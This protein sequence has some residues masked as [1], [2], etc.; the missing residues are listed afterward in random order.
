MPGFTSTRA[1][2][3]SDPLVW[4]GSGPPAAGDTA[5]IAVVGSA[6]SAAANN[7]SGLVR[8][9]V[10]STANW[11][12]G[13][14]AAIAGVAGTTEAN[15]FWVVTV[16][17]GTHIDLQGSA[18]VSAY[19]GG[20]RANCCVKVDVTTTVGSKAGGVGNGFT[21]NGTNATTF[22]CLLVA[23][24]VEFIARGFDVTSNPIGLV[25]QFGV[26][27]PLVGSVMTGD[28][29]SDYQSVLIN[30][31]RFEPQSGAIFGVPAASVSWASK[32]NSE[33]K[34][35]QAY[36][37][38]FNLVSVAFVNTHFSNGTQTGLG[39][40][41]DFPA[42]QTSGGNQGIYASTGFPTAPTTEVSVVFPATASQIAA[43]VNAAGKYA[44][45]YRTG[46]GYFFSSAPTV[47]HTISVNYFKLDRSA[48]NWRGWGV[49]SNGG[50][51]GNT[52]LTDG[53]T[54][55]YMGGTT[56]NA[57]TLSSIACSAPL[58]L[59]N[60]KTQGSSGDAT[61][62]GFAKNSTFNYGYKWVQ[63]LQC[64]GTAGDP[65][66]VTGNTFRE[67]S[68]SSLIDGLNFYNSYSQYVTVDSN[69]FHTRGT[70]VDMGI[71]TADVANL[72]ITNNTG[73]CG[74]AFVNS[75]G[76]AGARTPFPYLNDPDASYTYPNTLAGGRPSSPDLYVFGNAVGGIGGNGGTVDSRFFSVS[77]T[78]GH[79]A[80]VEF[81]D[82]SHCHRLGHMTGSYVTHRRNRYGQCYHHGFTGS[83]VDDTYVTDVRFETNLFWC[84]RGATGTNS[85]SA[86]IQPGYNHRVFANNLQIV[87]NTFD[88]WK[89]GAVDF[90]D[91]VD[92]NG[93]LLCTNAVIENNVIA[94][95]AYAFAAY[96][97]A[98]IPWFPHVL[99][100]DYNNVNNQGTAYA[101]TGTTGLT[102]GTNATGFY[103]STNKYNRLTSAQRNV[104]S[105]AL[106]DASYTTAQTGRSLVYTVNTVGVDHTLA[107]GA[108]DPVPLVASSGTS[109]GQGM[110]TVAISGKTDWAFGLTGT[111]TT[112]SA[113]ASVTG[114]GTAFTTELVVGDS[115]RLTGATTPDGISYKVS[116]IADDTHLTLGTNFVGS[117][118]AKTAT[119][120]RADVRQKWLW[121]VSGTGS[122]QARSIS[123]ASPNAAYAV[124]IVAGGTGYAVGQY[125]TVLGG[126]TDAPGGKVILKITAVSAGV[127]TGLQVISG[128]GYTVVPANPVTTSRITGV[129]GASCTVNLTW[130]PGLLLVPDLT[131]GLDATSVLAVVTPSVTLFDTA[132]STGGS[133]RAGIG[134]CDPPDP[135]GVVTLPTTSQTDAGI[136][137]AVNHSPT[138]SPAW[139]GSFPG[140]LPSLAA[141]DYR[142]G[143]ASAA[144]GAGSASNAP[145]NDY[146]GFPF[147]SPPSAGFGE[148]SSTGRARGVGTGGVLGGNRVGI[149]TGGMM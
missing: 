50:T 39:S 44:I 41:G 112:V 79:P 139:V 4:G 38:G 130:G 7:G 43:V 81:N 95:G 119:R 98:T 128:G 11:S 147:G 141:S 91:L 66:V 132:G 117:N 115:I 10:G 13:D 29:A 138:G 49:V 57:K 124:S 23:S 92:S 136:T 72:R 47:G 122:G 40:A 116:A 32:V 22:G 78:A 120:H 88:G 142:I 123:L 134:M 83:N 6:V 149:N 58:V 2:N 145:A 54:F 25:N 19:V 107:W 70:G 99:E 26:F 104:P 77:G 109:S 100:C 16:I 85:T 74:L 73:T 9:T 80:V 20:G 71:I 144:R 56:G 89:Y 30:K 113:S 148:F 75:A 53:S 82:L 106:F 31:G 97:S 1:G 28:V 143:P 129:A 36:N 24:G 51:A 21:V 45:D 35:P 14:Y 121:V 52:C 15:G 94:N 67:G 5:T 90:N 48:A 64:V 102:N 96:R 59:V 84:D 17:D 61:T 146:F 93:P 3:W 105:V 42:G 34:N 8:L 65:V 87:N 76:A 60:H 110:R 18:F 62:V 101:L 133:V 33:V 131:T 12:T 27:R 69:A 114:T 37:T 86:A 46:V 63:L 118:S 140:G 68:G 103:Q 127:I 135:T 55:N 108:G 126:T 125:L 111:L 137:V